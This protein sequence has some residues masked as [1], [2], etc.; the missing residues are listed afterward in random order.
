MSKR[1]I[2]KPIT[3]SPDDLILDPNNP[4]LVQDLRQSS[5]ISDRDAMNSKTQRAIENRFSEK[6]DSK[7]KS[8]SEDF[9][10]I[11][12]LYLSLIHI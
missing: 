9:T 3:V 12:D 6:S 8:Q 7:K 2:F 1:Q 5:K 11:K 4:R 10:N